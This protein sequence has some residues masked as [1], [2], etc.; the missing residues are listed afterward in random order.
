[1]HLNPDTRIT[2]RGPPLNNFPRCTLQV[3]NETAAAEAEA[4]GLRVV[5][6]RCPKIEF[7]RLFGELGWHGFN[8]GVISSKKNPV[9]K[10]S[11]GQGFTAAVPREGHRVVG[12]VY[13]GVLTLFAPCERVPAHPPPLPPLVW[14]QHTKG[15]AILLL[16]RMGR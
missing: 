10:A 1:M 11:Q 3:Q 12:E 7:S 9:G 6:N 16:T 8:T 14:Y 5:M 4:A 13:S 15:C 2:S